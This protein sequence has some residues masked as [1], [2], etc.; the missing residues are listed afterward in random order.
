MYCSR[1]VEYF[2][3]KED[4]RVYPQPRF[5]YLIKCSVRILNTGPLE[6][7]VNNARHAYQPIMIDLRTL[8]NPVLESSYNQI[9]IFYQL[10]S[11][12][13]RKFVFV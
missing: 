1:R 7:N 8:S 2:F 12:V 5:Y 3:L 11:R 6:R 13:V 9:P 10:L 4:V